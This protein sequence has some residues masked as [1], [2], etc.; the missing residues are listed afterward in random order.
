MKHLYKIILLLPLVLISCKQE[1]YY[2]VKTMVEPFESGSI[3]ME[4]SS[5][6]VLEGTSVTLTAQP[7]GDYVF[8]GWS[9]SISGKESPTT[10]TVSSDL[11]VTAHF[12]LR[13]YPLTLSV[14][15]EGTIEEKVVSSK[16]NYT[17]G[18]VVELTAKA[19]EDWYFDHWEGD[20]SGTDNPAQISVSSSRNVKAVFKPYYDPEDP[21]GPHFSEAVELISLVFRLMGADEYNLCRV[22][23]VYESA[24]SYFASMKNHAAISLARSCR[25]TGVSYDAVAAYGLYLEISDQGVISFNPDYVDNLSRWS[26]QQKNEM[27]TALNDFYQ[28]SNF[29]EWYL[30]LELYRQE[31]IKVFKKKVNIDLD[32]YDWFFGP[33]DNLS[34]Q[35]ILSFFI[36]NHNYGLS[37]DLKNGGMLL[38]PVIGCLAVNNSGEIIF[39]NDGSVIVHEFCHPYCNPL[40]YKYW[41]SMKEVA[42]SVYITVQELMRSQAYSTAETMMCETFVRASEVRY[43]MN[44]T[45]DKKQEGMILYELERGF[46]MVPTLVDILDKREQERSQYA[47]MEDFMPEIIKAINEYEVP[48]YTGSGQYDE[49]TYTS[50]TN[51]LPGIFSVGSTNK[52]QFTK[53]NLYWNGTEWQF[54]ANQMNYPNEWNP[55]HVGH[56]F[57]TKKAED[58]VAETFIGYNTATTSD[59]FFCDGSSATR[60]LAVEGI[61]GLRVL[62]DGQNGEIDY[63]LNKRP[64]AQNLYKFPVSI[65][66]VGNCLVLAPDDY[67]GTIKNSYD[68]TTWASAEA[69]GLVCLTAAGI[70][71]GNVVS[72]TDGYNGVYWTGTPK[73]NSAKHAYALGFSTTLSH[74]PSY[75]SRSAGASIRLVKDVTE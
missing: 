14:E 43:F 36:G 56:L 8:T 62:K 40:I 33:I 2:T 57:W 34:T 9:G 72:D 51:L 10:I 53:G 68:A 42:S 29:H 64:N 52:V 58:A 49:Y 38:S 5:G 74:Y 13:K 19:A 35:I 67:S 30:S 15:G 75:A 65:K 44:H 26:D 25:Q 47:T 73:E 48:N 32:W 70:R 21:N 31:A 18:M 55:Q 50:T 16:A 4:P 39:D 7:K 54:E 1:V 37:V 3:V 63:L 46:V 24:D 60:S 28:E 22:P 45:S 59:H 11:A 23:S 61:D 66:N 41:E 12:T 6:Q 17:S 20:L 27:L 69:A 71:W